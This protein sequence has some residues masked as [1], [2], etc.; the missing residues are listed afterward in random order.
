MLWFND[1]TTRYKAFV[2]R[3]CKNP[4]P[5]EDSFHYYNKAQ[6]SVV[7][8]MEQLSSDEGG[9]MGGVEIV[10]MLEVKPEERMTAVQVVERL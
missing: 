1:G 7:K 3:R 2:M 5:E 6:S 4:D 10:K 9:R 8:K